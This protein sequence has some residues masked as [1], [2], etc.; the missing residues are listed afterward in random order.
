M[1]LAVTR[2]LEEAARAVLGVRRVRSKTIRGAT[3]ISVLFN[4]DADMRYALQLMQGKTDEVKPSLPAGHRD[5][6]RADDAVDLPDLHVQPDG[7]VARQGPARP[8]G[9]RGAA[10]ARAG[11]LAWPTSRS[12]AS[13]EREISVIVDPER[14]SAA[15]LTID[16][17]ADALAGHQPGELGRP[18]RQGL[19]AVPRAGHR[20]AHEPR[21]RP[22]RRRRLPAAG[23]RLR[24]ATS[25]RSARASW[26]RRRS[27]A[28]TGSPPRWSAWRGRFTATSSTSWTARAP[29][30]KAT[31]GRCRR[32]SVGR[33]LYDLAEF[34]KSAVGSVRDAIVIGGLLAVFVLD[35]IPPRLAGHV[36]R[37]HLPAADA[38]GH[39][40]DP[41]P[42]RRHDRP[43]VA[44]RARD[45]DRPGHRRR[46]RRRREHPPAPRGGRNGCR[47]S[48]EGDARS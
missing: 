25:P 17:V 11:C 24:R 19:S 2:P 5:A 10:A 1:Q 32:R 21:R 18:A 12:L 44:R 39:V 31:G 45:R 26:T 48:R 13:E 15:K 36:H 40:L 42:R 27:S 6:G 8:R 30:S 22:Q 7:Q 23:A 38:R 28:A 14:L 3:E 34:V 46:D 29:P 37:R 16:Q 47:G 20:R 4:P 33:W 41:A 43:D 9:V 35:R